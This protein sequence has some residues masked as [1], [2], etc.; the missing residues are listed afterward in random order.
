MNESRLPNWLLP[1]VAA[2]ALLSAGSIYYRVRVESRNKA[3]EITVE[4]ETV[5]NLAASQGV[6]LDKALRS[7]KGSGLGSVVLSEL[8]VADLL[9]SRQVEMKVTGASN[10]ASPGGDQ[11]PYIEFVFPDS[12][13]YSK[14]LRRKLG[15][16]IHRR[17]P[18]VKLSQLSLG[19]TPAIGT[20]TSLTLTGDLPN[21][22]ALRQT[23]IGLAVDE[24][25]AANRASVR[26]IGRFGNPIGGSENYV[27]E[28]LTQAKADGM[29]AF[30]PQGDQVLG[31]REGLKHMEEELASNDLFYCSPEF[32]KLGGDANVVSD[33]P[34]RVIRLHSAQAAELDKLPYV[35]AVDRYV[36]AARE[37]NQ[38]LLLLRPVSF[39]GNKPLEDFRQFVVDVRK[40]VEKQGGAIGAAKPFQESQT[41]PLVFGLLGLAMIGPVWYTLGRFLPSGKLKIAFLVAVALVGAACFSHH[42]RMP[43]A[44]A[45][46]LAF[47]ILAFFW[48][49]DNPNLPIPLKYFGVTV[50]SMV[51]GMCVAGLLNGLPYFIH[52]EQFEGVK[53]AVFLPIV[54]VG[55]HYMRRL[56]DI[57]AILKD[58]ITYRQALIGIVIL[59]ALGFMISRT[60]ND[61]P[62]GVSG[63]ELKMRDVLDKL[64]FVRPRTKE[65]LFGH[66]FL[67]VGI[68]MLAWEQSRQAKSKSSAPLEVHWDSPEAESVAESAHGPASPPLAGWTALALMMGAVGQTDVVNTLCHMH[69]P[70]LLAFARIAVGW[71]AGGILG[72][73]LWSLIARLLRGYGEQFG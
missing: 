1:L 67:V 13:A 39:S 9:N 32:A 38:R 30:L 56:G 24:L 26:I 11:L 60:G 73:V 50:L 58:P 33:I 46:T 69:S 34:E 17:F 64:L 72:L 48:L 35:E 61:N 5:E 20:D 28:T 52:A 31:R 2:C 12:S 54:A 71:L 21:V 68:C 7:L 49:D 41:P 70:I 51:G 45:G 6:S 59:A 3:T 43:M 4:I 25:A 37:R 10:A 27:T 14:S 22:F 42:Y 29:Y 57:R 66:P 36:R 40:G 47:P 8:T 15:E 53:V 18:L 65:F 44:F 63:A 62:A 55:I 19:G 16:G 23:S